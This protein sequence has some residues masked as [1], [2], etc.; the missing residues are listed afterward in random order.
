MAC[1][2]GCRDQ[3]LR[4][5]NM[6][7]V[8]FDLEIVGN[9][10]SGNLNRIEQLVKNAFRPFL[11]DGNRRYGVL[12]SLDDAKILELPA[13]HHLQ[14]SVMQSRQVDS[15][16]QG[17]SRGFR[18]IDAN[19][20]RPLVLRQRGAGQI[21]RHRV[22]RRRKRVGDGILHAGFLVVENANYGNGNLCGFGKRFRKRAE[23]PACHSAE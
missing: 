3:P 15:E 16:S 4:S 20:D 19:H 13:E 10:G 12:I 5:G 9:A 18:T 8:R 1:V 7:G 23:E 17:V 2:T 21:V 11:T 6:E 22:L 14:G